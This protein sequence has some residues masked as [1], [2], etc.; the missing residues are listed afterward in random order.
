MHGGL[1]TGAKTREEKERSRQAAKQGML[2]YWKNKKLN[3]LKPKF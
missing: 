2:L 1:S 3:C